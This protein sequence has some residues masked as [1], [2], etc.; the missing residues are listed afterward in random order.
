M[1]TSL[2]GPFLSGIA[3]FFESGTIYYL[4]ECVFILV[5][6]T[7][8]IFGV[9]LEFSNGFRLDAVLSS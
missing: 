1:V 2:A 5:F 6:D 3:I 7:I 9:V 4:F 8:L